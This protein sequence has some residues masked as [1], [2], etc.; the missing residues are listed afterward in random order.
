MRNP[1]AEINRGRFFAESLD[2]KIHLPPIM[3]GGVK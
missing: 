2:V 1:P 3:T